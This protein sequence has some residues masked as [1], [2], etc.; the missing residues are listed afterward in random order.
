MRT[1][2]TRGGLEDLEGDFAAV[3]DE[4]VLAVQAA[5]ALGVAFEDVVA[6]VE[7]GLAETAFLVAAGGVRE[8]LLPTGVGGGVVETF[9]GEVLAPHTPPILG[10]A[11]AA[12]VEVFG[13]TGGFGR[14]DMVVDE[15]E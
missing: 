12:V 4:A 15:V 6:R 10:V 7:E 13:D 2:A 14:A 9:A 1:P 5:V 3:L 8:H 11:V